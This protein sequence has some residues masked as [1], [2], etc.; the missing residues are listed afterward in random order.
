MIQIS[1]GRF[2]IAIKILQAE[3][4][5]KDF[6]KEI[7]LKLD[8]YRANK[9]VMYSKDE[10]NVLTRT[11][12]K[13]VQKTK[14]YKIKKNSFC[15]QYLELIKDIKTLVHLN[16][17]KLNGLINKI[18]AINISCKEIVKKQFLND[19]EELLNYKKFRK[20]VIP[21]FYKSL[22]IKVCVYCNTQHTIFLN[23]SQLGR[24]QADHNIAKSKY[25]FLAITLS[26]LY[27]TCNNCNHLKNKSPLDFKLY[28]KIKSRQ[29]DFSA[30]LEESDIVAFISENFD[31]SKLS[32]KFK[33]VPHDFKN[34]IRP[35]EIYENHKDYAGDLIKK[36]IIY[37]QTYKDELTKNF[38]ELFPSTSRGVHNKQLFDR[39]I[40]GS[41][42]EEND[43]H[44]RVFSKLNID[45]MKQLEKLSPEK[46]KI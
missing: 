40:Y 31:E 25:P 18:N 7:Q 5:C 13:D 11:A 15:Y 28:Y 37:N 22:G 17:F 41:S 32:I 45:I 19:I 16:P 46:L 42:L 44:K 39:L 14:E 6:I 12:K 20:E 36:K 21:L 34:T 24:Y 3:D 1:E 26:N 30:Y 29:I 43:I 4:T 23:K 33:D 8:E 2:K 38:R 35:E 10:K 9:I 27:P